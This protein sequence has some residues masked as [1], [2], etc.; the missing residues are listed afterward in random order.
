MLMITDSDMTE[1]GRGRSGWSRRHPIIPLAL[2]AM[3]RKGGVFGDTKPADDASR[4]V[5]YGGMGEKS[6]FAANLTK[7]ISCV[8]VIYL[9]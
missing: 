7:K 4:G 9:I 6:A 5:R 8:P 3:G 2:N 1:T